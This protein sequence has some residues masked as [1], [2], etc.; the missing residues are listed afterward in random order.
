MSFLKYDSNIN[1]YKTGTRLSLCSDIL[2]LG[3]KM[4]KNSLLWC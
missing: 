1:K 3:S 4:L 2:V